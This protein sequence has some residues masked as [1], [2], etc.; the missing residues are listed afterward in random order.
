MPLEESS[1]GLPTTALAALQ[2]QPALAA[3]RRGI[4]KESLRVAA[5]GDLAVTP[6][7]Q[8]LGSPL[9]HP[10]ITTDFSEAQLELITGVHGSVAAALAEL[11]DIHRFVYANIGDELLWTSS[12]PCLLGEEEAIPIARFGRSN[13]GRSKTIYRIGLSHRYG[14]RMQTISGIHYNFS[15]PEV[16]WPGIAE[17]RGE[18]VDRNSIASAYFG[19]IRN[20][21]RYSWLLIY[22]FGASPAVCRSFVASRTATDLAALDEGTLH[23]PWATSL[24]MGRLGYQSDAQASLH[25]SYNSLEQYAQTMRNALTAPYPAYEAIGLKAQSAR[26]EDEYRQLSTAL[27]QIENEFYG[28]IRPKRRTRSGERPLAAL[29]ERGVEYVELRCLDLDPFQPLGIDATTCRV[30]DAFLLF[31]LLDRSPPDSRAESTTLA[32]NQIKVVERGREPG[33]T[34]ARDGKQVPLRTWAEEILRSCMEVA[35]VIDA[36]AGSD[37]HAAAVAEQQRKVEEPELTPSARVLAAMRDQGEPFFRFALDQSATQQR[38]FAER[39]LP[40]ERH[41]ELTALGDQSLRAQAQIEQSE[42][43][44]FD[45]YLRRYIELP[46]A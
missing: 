30:L 42:T 37:D 26:E 13:A 34:L 1:R 28:T 14:R 6:H 20:F 10:H 44:R 4:E 22:L 39:P 40:A 27:L 33:L 19:L 29:H 15:L 25:I 17:S 8:R 21:R 9:T 2:G 45:S 7:P 3:L 41:R 38:W 24:R 23:L 35:K 11:S 46:G 12:M 43:E 16:L 32:A 18:R 31:C 5:N 36:V